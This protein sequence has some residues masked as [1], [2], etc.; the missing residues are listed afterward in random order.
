VLL[1]WLFLRENPSPRQLT[2]LILAMAAVW[3]LSE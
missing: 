3:L 1:S 2:G